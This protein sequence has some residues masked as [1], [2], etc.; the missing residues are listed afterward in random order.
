MRPFLT[1]HSTRVFLAIG[2]CLATMTWVSAQTQEPENA[3]K[4]PA[5]TQS[6]A[7]TNRP[8]PPGE[9][10]NVAMTPER[11]A[12]ALKFAELHHAE[13][14]QLIQGLK[15]ANRPEYQKAVR[16]LYNDSERLARLKERAADR[17]DLVLKE[18]QVDSRLRLLVARMTMS[19]GDPELEGQLKELLQKR[20]DARL[21][22]LKFDQERQAA[23]LAKLDEQIEQLESDRET[24]VEKELLQIQ[25]SLGVNKQKPKKPPA[26]APKNP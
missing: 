24:S 2:L 5:N 18:W 9:S 26:S 13:L 19:A 6:P 12:A 17:Y 23:R 16:Q 11:Q 14:H 4:T 7:K 10:V 1:A 22:L 8:M 20:V 15:K 3:A 25:R 21:N